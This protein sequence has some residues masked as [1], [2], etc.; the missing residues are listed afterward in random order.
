[1]TLI[2]HTSVRTAHWSVWRVVKG[3][4][5]WLGINQL[6]PQNIVEKGIVHEGGI[7]VCGIESQEPTKLPDREVRTVYSF[8]SELT[9]H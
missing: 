7:R 4:V 3:S 9:K 1:M 2:P 5:A 8:L 6:I